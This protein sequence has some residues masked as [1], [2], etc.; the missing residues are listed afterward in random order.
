MKLFCLTLI[1]LVITFWNSAFA[2]ELK[3]NEVPKIVVENFKKKYP[4]VYVY[5]WE[6]KKKKMVYEA[7]FIMKGKRYEAHYTKDGQWI[8]TEREVQKSEIPQ[9]VWDNFNKTQFANWKIDDQEEHSTPKYELVYE[10]KVKN[11]KSKVFLYF[12]PD[13]KQVEIN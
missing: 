9:A 13:G 11:N 12:L 2:Q 5:E 3:E 10:I 4:D 7:E 6:W 1:V 8:K